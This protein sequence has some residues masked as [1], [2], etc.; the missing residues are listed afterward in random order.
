[1]RNFKIQFKC[2]PIIMGNEV[3][4]FKINFIY[5]FILPIL[6]QAEN[7]LLYSYIDEGPA[8]FFDSAAT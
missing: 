6:R 3:P 8:S 5:F 4:I 2:D 1:M 7:C